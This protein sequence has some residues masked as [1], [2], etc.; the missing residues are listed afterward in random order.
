MKPIY[1]YITSN[2]NI[3]CHLIPQLLTRLSNYVII[4]QN[5]NI[6]FASMPFQMNQPRQSLRLNVGFLIHQ[7]VGSSRDFYFDLPSLFLEPD[8]SLQDLNGSARI[9]RTPQGLLVQVKMRATVPA[10]C[11]RCLA[12]LKQQLNTDFTELYAFSI[13]TAS[14]SEL[15]LPEDGHIDLGPLVREYML[16]EIPINPVCHPECPGICAVCGEVQ[17]EQLHHHEVEA[18]D[19]RLAV[20]KTLLENQ[21]S[22]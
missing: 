18:G 13:R 17:G 6:Y 9:T 5:N 22:E 14:E 1:T 10:E 21:T 16:L 11:V 7:S 19:P 15:I 20:L 3:L 12:D 4:S 8:L 2:I